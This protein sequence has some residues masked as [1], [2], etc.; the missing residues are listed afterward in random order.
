MYDV[1]LRFFSLNFYKCYNGQQPSIGG[2]GGLVHSMHASSG[3]LHEVVAP[4]QLLVEIEQL[5]FP[6]DEFWQ[7]IGVVEVVGWSESSKVAVSADWSVG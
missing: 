4:V 5:L 3:P 7:D 2:G 6:K 1:R